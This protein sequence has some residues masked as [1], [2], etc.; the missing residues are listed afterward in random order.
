MDGKSV[1]GEGRGTLQEDDFLGGCR[2]RAAGRVSRRLGHL[3]LG[4]GAGKSFRMCRGG[5]CAS[6]NL[7]LLEVEVVPGANNDQAAVTYRDI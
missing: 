6:G 7:H 2:G 3:R 4:G 1:N 5:G